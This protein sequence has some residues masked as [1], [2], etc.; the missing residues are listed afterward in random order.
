MGAVVVDS[1]DKEWIMR[2]LRKIR[3]KIQILFLF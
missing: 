2:I 3:K 1:F